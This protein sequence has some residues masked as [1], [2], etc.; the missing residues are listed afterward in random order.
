MHSPERQRNGTADG[1]GW[2]C[3]W[4]REKEVAAIGGSEDRGARQKQQ[5]TGTQA[6]ATPPVEGPGFHEER[7]GE[8]VATPTPARA[9]A[10]AEAAAAAAVGSARAGVTSRNTVAARMPS[11]TAT[12]AGDSNRSTWTLENA[13][14]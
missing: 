12:R 11:M 1:K 6:A 10:P 2:G 9:P 7:V 14:S 13:V 3:V 5:Q 8:G 4:E